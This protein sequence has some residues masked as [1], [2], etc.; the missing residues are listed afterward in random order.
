MALI[1]YSA[2][3]LRNL[4]SSILP[5]C[6]DVIKSL[7][8]LRRPR[9]VHRASRHKFVELSTTS[10]V[11]A[12]LWCH[13]SSSRRRHQNKNYARSA[14][15][16]PLTCV[17]TAPCTVLTNKSATFMLQNTRSLNNKA[18]LIYDIITDRKL[19]FMCLTE[20]WQN[21][22][23]FL[24]LNQ[25]TPPGYNY[26]Q[27]PRSLG[28]GGGLAVIYNADIIVKELPT[29]VVTFECVHFVM[30]GAVQLQVVLV[31]RPPKVPKSS[32]LPEFSELLSTVC[33][34][35]PSTLIL[36]DFNIHLDSSN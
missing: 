35:S 9:Y 6:L 33:P 23:D 26:I 36:G 5:S 25:A 30:A 8:L 32:F 22:Q 20:T 7:Q 27:K 14:N 29:N 24:S 1:R 34:M 16:R 17:D 18:G 21:Q 11:S 4:C 12:V 15:L 13:A 10:A 28:R 19:D 2:A 31:Y 3:E